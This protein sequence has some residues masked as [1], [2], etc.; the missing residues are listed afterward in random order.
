MSDD[1]IKRLRSK[2]CCDNGCQCDEAA[3]RIAALEAQVAAAK[4]EQW[5]PI[6]TAPKNGSWFDVW[7]IAKNGTGP[8]RL[9]CISW[10]QDAWRWPSVMSFSDAVGHDVEEDWEITHWQP[11]PKGPD[12]LRAIT[13]GAANDTINNSEYIPGLNEADLL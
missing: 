5:F 7:A 12:A 9:D 6:E 13:D 11:C 1:L 3:D 10:Q 4:A 8:G 2:H